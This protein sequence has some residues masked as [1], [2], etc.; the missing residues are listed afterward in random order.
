MPVIDTSISSAQM[1]TAIAQM[2]EWVTQPQVSEREIHIVSRRT[3]TPERREAE[4]LPVVEGKKS[5]AS[6]SVP[7]SDGKAKERK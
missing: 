4:S 2:N 1:D 5:H 3:G 6:D 7:P